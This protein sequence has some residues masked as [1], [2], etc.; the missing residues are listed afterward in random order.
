MFIRTQETPNPQTLKFIPQEK[1]LVPFTMTFL[2][3]EDA[4]ASPFAQGLLRINGIKGVFITDDFITVTKSPDWEWDI[5]KPLL[6]ASIMDYLVTGKPIHIS[7]AE[8]EVGSED[9]DEIVKQIK[10]LIE[11]KVRPA[12]AEDGGDI[13]YRGF[14]DGIVYLEMQ[15]AC[16]G[17]PSSSITLK[18]GVENML[19]H[20]IPEVEA[21]EAV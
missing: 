1:L 17:C 13:V 12:V 6:L 16:S 14:K 2:T 9:D 5:L 11:T 3:G 7:N 10:E 18:S 20:Y 8:A 4:S 15:G 21:V 19:K